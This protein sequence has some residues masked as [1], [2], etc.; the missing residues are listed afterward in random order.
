MMHNLTQHIAYINQFNY[1]HILIFFRRNLMETLRIKALGEAIAIRLTDKKWPEYSQD[2]VSEVLSPSTFVW[3][4]PHF[5]LSLKLGVIYSQKMPL[6][7]SL[8]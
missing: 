8:A 7:P 6:T 2:R 5:P 3:P 4:T 1:P